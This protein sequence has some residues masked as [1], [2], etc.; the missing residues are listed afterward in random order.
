MACLLSKK[1]V[2]VLCYDYVGMLG[3]KKWVGKGQAARR[4][5]VED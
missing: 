5:N 2:L 1:N 4:G 3:L